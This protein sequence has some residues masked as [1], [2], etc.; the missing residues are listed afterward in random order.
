MTVSQYLAITFNSEKEYQTRNP[1]ICND[2]FEI[3]AQGSIGH[4][5]SP[6]MHTNRYLSLELGYPSQKDN[7]IIKYAEDK[8]NL[9][10][11]V[12]GWV[13][14]EIV[15]ELIKKHKGID[16]DKTFKL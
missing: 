1:I 8:K 7:L 5:C 4:Y 11:T 16:I 2:G 15:E 14:I 6:R 9:C 10:N 3:S 13:P 12:Y